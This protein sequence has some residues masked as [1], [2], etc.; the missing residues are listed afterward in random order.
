LTFSYDIKT[1]WGLFNILYSPNV[2]MTW[3][4]IP[5]IIIMAVYRCCAYIYYYF[6]NNISFHNNNCTLRC[7]EIILSGKF[8]TR[9]CKH[10]CGYYIGYIFSYI[11]IL[12]ICNTA[13]NSSI[14][15]EINI[16]YALSK[17]LPVPNSLPSID[18]R[19]Q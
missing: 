4:K 11:H 6:Y 5:P 17:R 18:H 7:D 8:Y 14:S 15:F 2:R 10:L 13:V 16:I 9:L 19:T 3:L 1:P 12:H